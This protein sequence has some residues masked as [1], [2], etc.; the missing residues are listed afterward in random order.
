MIRYRPPQKAGSKYIT[1]EGEKTLKAEL[2][3]LWKVERP[4]VTKSVSEAAALGDR[5]ENAE[6]IYGKKR[7]QEIDRRVRYLGNR[8]EE[9]TVVSKPP[10]D[11]TKVYFAA[12]ISLEDKEGKPY[13]YRLVGPD[14]INPHS[15]YISMDSPMGKALLGRK[16]DD[17]V[18]IESPT[19][20][21]VYY[22]TAIDY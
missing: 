2:H 19:G 11:L 7:L 13:R 9:M 6:Y 5:S 16:I 10:D 22:I 14:E 15:S 21:K 18:E 3:Q 1:A 17:E 12:Y 8:L 20:S 4:I